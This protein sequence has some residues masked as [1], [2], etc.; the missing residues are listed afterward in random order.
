[1]R[2]IGWDRSVRVA[3]PLS[4]WERVEDAITMSA[5]AVASEGRCASCFW[6]RPFLDALPL[7]DDAP[8]LCSGSGAEGRLHQLDFERGRRSGIHVHGDGDT[9]TV[10][11]PI[12]NDALFRPRCF[13]K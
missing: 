5:G 2:S 7:C 9:P 6:L 1:M 11:R 3:P 10:D 13:L 8:P 12:V 4:S